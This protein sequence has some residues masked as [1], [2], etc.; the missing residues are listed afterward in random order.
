[1]YEVEVLTQLVLM[2]H[3]W[4]SHLNMRCVDMFLECSMYL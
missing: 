3:E 2:E 4:N 1:M